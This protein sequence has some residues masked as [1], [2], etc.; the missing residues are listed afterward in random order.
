MRW[1]ASRRARGTEGDPVSLAEKRTTTFWNRK[2]GLVST[3]TIKGESRIEA[4]L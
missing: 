4:V 3:P 2:I 1:T